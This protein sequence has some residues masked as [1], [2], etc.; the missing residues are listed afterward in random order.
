MK[1]GSKG[2]VVGPTKTQ[3]LLIPRVSGALFYRPRHDGLVLMVC[4]FLLFLL[5]LMGMS[6][7][8]VSRLNV[9][10][11]QNFVGDYLAMGAAYSAMD[12]ALH[13]I[14]EVQQG[15]FSN[16]GAGGKYLVSSFDHNWRALS[17][18]QA[19][20][21]LP[22]VT[23]LSG[24]SACV[25][26]E[27]VVTP[28]ST[29]VVYRITASASTLHAYAVIQAWVHQYYLSSE[30]EDVQNEARAEARASEGA[31]RVTEL[32]GLRAL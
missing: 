26:I 14:W 22:V 18:W 7:A 3:H 28:D 1:N 20:N 19:A 29:D 9:Y 32:R 8:S 16:A 21:C 6:A 13:N 31:I 17:A 25:L 4:L 11:S 10:A 27:T 2:L 12:N 24:T 30:R 5:S 23:E 15:Q